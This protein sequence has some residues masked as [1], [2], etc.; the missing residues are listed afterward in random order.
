MGVAKKVI[1]PL[2]VKI[3]SQYLECFF[4]KMKNQE[5]TWLE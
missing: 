2:K 3:S 4:K 1:L 5:V